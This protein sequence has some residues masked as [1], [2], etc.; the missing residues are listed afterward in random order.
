MSV[1]V[2]YIVTAARTILLDNFAYGDSSFSDAELIGFVGRA[3]D[4][5]ADLSGSCNPVT[6]PLSL[7]AGTAQKLPE[8]GGRILG[9]LH[10]DLAE[11]RFKVGTI[12]YKGKHAPREITYD[13]LIAQIPAF[14]STTPSAGVVHIC[15]DPVSPKEF[16]VCPPNNGSGKLFVRYTERPV[17]VTAL[18]DDFPLGAEFYEPVINY[19]LFLCLSRDGEDT[20]NST[21]SADFLKMASMSLQGTDALK[22]TLSARPTM[23]T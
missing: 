18:T 12:S 22:M 3:T 11:A 13:S 14:A 19:V 4:F 2:S 16:V 1:K 23:R 8:T 6:K 17:H 7:A 15:F 10:N 21:R 9:F 20:A 5:C